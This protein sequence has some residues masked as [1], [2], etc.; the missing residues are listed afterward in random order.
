MNVLLEYIL[1]RTC[2]VCGCQ[3]GKD[4]RYL[5]LK[6]LS[7][8][9]RSNFHRIQNNP[10]EQ[11]FMGIVPY[12]RCSGLL[13]YTPNSELA[14][15]LHDMKYRKFPGLG[16]YMGELMGRELLN[17][18]FFNGVDLLMPIPMH[19]WK[20]ARRG[21]N[22]A[23]Q[24]CI[25][26]SK[27]TGIPIDKSLRAV[28]SHRTQTALNHDQRMQN[29]KDIFTVA[30]PERLTG[31][32]ILLIDDVCTTGATLTAAAEPLVRALDYPAG[33]LSILSL[34]VTF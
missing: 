6:C 1:P 28:R 13:L 11:R 24:L 30:H 32:H 33:R 25:G 5:C 23:E 2:H 17:T 7:K 3:L 31:K 15:V 19:W 29:L 14:T 8:L 12:E 22:Q 16:R 10:M 34:A 26:I 18:G 9:P 21:Y 4:E 27:I 20:R